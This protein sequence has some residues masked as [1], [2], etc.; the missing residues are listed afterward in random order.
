MTTATPA[1]LRT[2]TATRYVTALREGGSLPGLVEADDDGMYVVKFRGAGQGTK[3]LI[4]DLVVGEI[5]RALGLLV[6]EMVL[7]DVD[8]ELARSEPDYETRALLQASPGLNLGIDFLPGSMGFDALDRHDV[9]PLLASKIVWFDAYA[10]N[11]DRTA[12]N[13][14]ML[15]WHKRL[16]LI[17]HGA[18]LYFHHTWDDYLKRSLSPFT[19]IKDHVLL[20]VAR[21][22]P[23]AEAELRG[24]LRPDV[25]AAIVGLIPDAWLR[26]E[27]RFPDPDAHR[28][29]YVE[30]LLRRLEASPIFVEEALRARSP[31]L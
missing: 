9:D 13:P 19:P 31:R 18:A 8:P 7:I 25:L 11:V 26:D 22:L 17:D 3:A 29:A 1:A 23:E 14:N 4:A 24:K 6:P 16:W 12:R 5:G 21:A 27:P 2:V 28:A 10:T 30:Y 20:L 15:H